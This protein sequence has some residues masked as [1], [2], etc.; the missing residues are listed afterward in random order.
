LA[1]DELAESTS[2][3]AEALAL[4][5]RTTRYGCNWH[6]GH[7][8]YSKAAYEVLHQKF[9]TTT[10]ATQTPF[11]FDCVNFYNQTSTTGGKCPSPDWPKQ[12]IPR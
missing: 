3:A 5:I 12:K 1:Q 7:G 11:W 8:S 9:G 10:W 4:A 6:G 2:A